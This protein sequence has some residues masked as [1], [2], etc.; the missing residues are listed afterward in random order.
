[1]EKTKDSRRNRAFVAL[2]TALKTAMAKNIK[3]D[4]YRMGLML[5]DA[6]SNAVISAVYAEIRKQLLSGKV[7]RLSGMGLLFPKSRGGSRGRDPITGTVHEIARAVRVKLK[8][9]K[10]FKKDLDK[11]FPDGVL[12]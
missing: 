2:N 6:Q 5:T 4:L 10:S 9:S 3:Y 1:M 11:I 12:E 7:V 8:L